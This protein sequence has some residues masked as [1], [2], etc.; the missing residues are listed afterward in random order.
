MPGAQGCQ[1]Q[2]SCTSVHQLSRQLKTQPH[3]DAGFLG[4][5]YVKEMLSQIARLQLEP[6]PVVQ[7]NTHTELSLPSG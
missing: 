4:Y 2:T 7:P 5:E 6:R 1:K 3:G